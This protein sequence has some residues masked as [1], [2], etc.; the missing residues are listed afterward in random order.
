MLLRN[1]SK[2]APFVAAD[3]KAL[4]L[5]IMADLC[6]R[7]FDDDQ[8]AKMV[9]PGAPDIHGVNA[10]AVFGEQLGWRHPDG[11]N[12]AELP[13][14][15]FKED[16]HCMKLRHTIKTVWYGLQ[17]GK[18]GFGFSTLEGAD[19][20]PI[21]EKVASAMVY[22]LLEAVPGLRRWQEW[23]R[24]W[25]DRWHGIYSLDGR[26]CSFKAEFMDSAPKWSKNR[27][28]RRA[29]N[30]PLQAT[31][32][33]IIGEAMINVA[34]CR[35]LKD[36]DLGVQHVESLL[37]QCMTAATANGTRLLVP[38]EVAVSHGENYWEC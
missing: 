10:K 21:G 20:K 32:A 30:F 37:E 24:T 23:C 36:P 13:V 28:Y 5:V 27:A 18:G 31:G 6:L 1:V 26:W 17:Y 3:Y 29:Y 8:L 9:A 2:P 19:G 25:V 22:A 11:R 35:D 12:L 16:P 38:L 7:L 34:R 33:G 14:S 15:A 4:E